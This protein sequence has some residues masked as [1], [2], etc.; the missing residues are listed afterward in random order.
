MRYLQKQDGQER[1]DFGREAKMA[2][3]V[4]RQLVRQAQRYPIQV[5]QGL[6]WLAFREALAI[7]ARDGC[8]HVPRQDG[9][10]L[11]PL[12]HHSRLRRG[13]P[14]RLHG[15]HLADEKLHR[16]HRLHG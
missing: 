11:G 6:R 9:G 3:L 1:G 2:M 14:C 13:P 8:A 10:V 15:W 12:A 16:A 5:S 4:M 7:R